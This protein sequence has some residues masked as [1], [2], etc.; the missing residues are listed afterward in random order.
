MK[1]ERINDVQ[2]KFVLT[3]TDL[4]KRSLDV[5]DLAYGSSKTEE[6]F[7]DIIETASREFSFNLEDTPL[8][9]E[10]VPM[11]KSSI[12][13]ML[14]KVAGGEKKV[15]PMAEGLINKLNEMK[16]K[17]LFDETKVSKSDFQTQTELAS[18]KKV[19]R[20]ISAN[21]KKCFIYSFESLDAISNVSRLIKKAEVDSSVYKLKDDYMLLVETSKEKADK[22][23]S[24]NR[25]LAEHGRRVNA[26]GEL[27]KAYLFENGEKIIAQNAISIMAKL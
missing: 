17:N 23:S 5:N 27:G 7:Q 15:S 10:A 6:L 1:V 22:V 25:I 4:D 12:T 3:K 8:M 11:S 9:I 21:E 2:I 24:A 26:Q 20:K 18:K 19:S 13:I 16:N 14:T